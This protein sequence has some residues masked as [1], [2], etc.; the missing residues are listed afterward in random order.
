MVNLDEKIKIDFI[1]MK[2]LRKLVVL[3]IPSQ[4]DLS[5]QMRV[6]NWTMLGKMMLKIHENYADHYWKDIGGRKKWEQKMSEVFKTAISPAK[7]F[8]EEDFDASMLTFSKFKSKFIENCKKNSLWIANIFT[9]ELDIY[10][11]N[12]FYKTLQISISEEWNEKQFNA[13]EVWSGMQN[14]LLLSIFQTYA[15]LMGDAVIFGIEE[16]ELFLYPHAQRGLYKTFRE[17]SKTTQ[18]LYTTHN[19]AFLDA[20]KPEEIS[21]L[22]KTKNGTEQIIKDDIKMTISDEMRI[23]SH[24]NIE[25]N[26]IFFANR[27][28]LVEW[29]SEKMIFTN[30]CERKWIDIEWLWIS[31]IECGWKTWVLY[32]IGVC[33]L[34][35][36][37]YFAIWDSDNLKPDHTVDDKYKN[38]K[39]TLENWRWIELD[40]DIEDYIIK[41][42]HTWYCRTSDKILN[43]YNWSMN[44]NISS[45]PTRFESIFDYIQTGK[46][47]KYESQKRISIEDTPF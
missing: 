6:S 3:Y 32:F 40:D 45:I 42:G 38:I 24:F 35:G 43:A 16:P 31:V 37:E 30:L 20:S 12:W 44:V 4:R 22:R 36:L 7:D 25:R 46:L 28:V 2:L 41:S 27:I 23:Y 10:D 13:L 5:D 34:S 17:L 21:M 8:L 33:R 15:E 19:P 26:E 14:L 47:I 29:P 39:T 9:P 11:V 18:I 1:W